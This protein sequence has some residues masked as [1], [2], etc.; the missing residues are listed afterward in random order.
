MF[1]GTPE[2]RSWQNRSS[3]AAIPF[4]YVRG[5]HT[6]FPGWY[7]PSAEDMATDDLPHLYLFFSME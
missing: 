5:L 2:K 1:C 7:F 3:S 6:G 4:A